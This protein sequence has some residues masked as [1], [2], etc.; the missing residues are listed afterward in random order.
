MATNINDIE[1]DN[2]LS[3]IEIW[4]IFRRRGKFVFKVFF[5]L[6]GF[7]FVYTIFQRTFNPIYVG[8]FSLLIDDPLNKKNRASN[9]SD[10]LIE[11]LA[12][13]RT[14]NDI[15]TLIE[16]LK[17][18]YLL[19]ELASEYKISPKALS[20]RIDIKTGGKDKF[21]K[22]ANGILKV[23]LRSK[24]PKKDQK[25]LKSLSELYLQTALNQKRQRLIDGLNFLNRQ[26][27]ELARK[28]AELQ[29]ELA[30]F[31]QNN[32]LLEPNIEGSSLKKLEEDVV[33][34]I[35]RLEAERE[36]LENISKELKKGNVNVLGFQIG[37][38]A[39]KPN[40][41]S[42]E[43][44][45]LAV[46]T[47]DQSLLKEILL[48]KND[49][50][51]ALSKYQP[52]S[53]KVLSIKGRLKLLEPKL[54]ANQLE[55]VNTALKLNLSSLNTAKVQRNKL[56]DT[57]SKQ[58]ELIKEFE[59]IQQK[60]NIA[61]QNLSG[62]I[63]ARETFQLEMAQRSFPWTIIDGP[64]IINRPISPSIPKNVVYGLFLSTIFSLLLGLLRE[65]SDN[66]FYYSKDIEESLSI[67][68]LA[69]I[70]FVE[71]FKNVK[72]DNANLLNSIEEFSDKDNINSKESQYQRFFYQESLR[73]LYTSIRFSSSDADIKVIEITSC[74]PEEGKSLINILF[75]KTLAEIGKKVLL[76]DLDL[77][78]PQVHKRLGLNNII[79]V[80]NYL[81]DKNLELS[82]VVQNIENNPN[83][84]V[85]TAGIKPPDPTLLLSSER[86]SNLIKDLKK[87]NNYDLVLLDTTPIIGISDSVLVSDLADALILVVSL[88][89]VE[90]SMPKSALQIIS[91][92]SSIKLGFIAN[93][94]KTPK[95]ER[96]PYGYEYGYG[97]GYG[98]GYSNYASY[99]ENKDDSD[100]EEDSS[101]LKSFFDLDISLLKK[102]FKKLSDWIDK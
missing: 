100:N 72:E 17:S 79:G 90:R 21:G 75:A 58:P 94:V 35:L 70:P 42:F 87:N 30:I 101:L 10:G 62:L 36:R 26:A 68:L 64:I 60:L 12:R 96:S 39:N 49:L 27:P 32:S 71:N 6:I 20:S 89:K 80:S 43:S 34:E 28:T 24:F 15:P 51:K 44:R 57:F 63:S 81:T 33:V 73:S 52:N 7:V 65:W 88:R 40:N 31:R 91:E 67:P 53:K 19:S 13:N 93:N 3:F 59:T 25:L 83:L 2:Q 22:V 86:I 5:I 54:L 4:S 82:D 16:L 48:V 92:T 29:T 45:G 18:P 14:D 47:N 55:A 23:S 76:V 56:K 84:S 85:I 37:S 102:Y 97:Y 46:T 9:L 74:I 50:A 1:S 69:N 8:R 99:V 98:Y 41:S 78:K 61:Q 11:D 66:V 77:R 38:N 95:N